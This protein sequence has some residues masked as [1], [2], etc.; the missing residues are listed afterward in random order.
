MNLGALELIPADRKKNPV[1]IMQMKNG[2]G[3]NHSMDLFGAAGKRSSGE[4]AQL[5]EA[6][7]G[8]LNADLGGA[9]RG[10]ENGAN[11]ADVARERAVRK[12]IEIDLGFLAELKP[13]N[14]VLVNVADN[15]DRGEIGDGEGGGRAGESDAGGR[16]VG[17][18]CATIRR[19][20]V[21]KH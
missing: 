16:R 12:R 1:A 21:R 9:Q 7:I 18:V 8:D 4:H 5:Q 6:G 11:V 17:D 20:W 13:G 10:I 2:L 19:R 14:V 3:G 15:P